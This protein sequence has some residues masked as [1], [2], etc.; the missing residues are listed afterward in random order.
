M[1]PMSKK[2][3]QDTKNQENE[4]RLLLYKYMPYEA[5]EKT[6]ENWSL[7]L[8]IPYET[9]DPFEFMARCQHSKESTD[10][11]I[12]TAIKNTPGMLCF[13]TSMTVASMW[14][15]YADKH[16]GVCLIFDFPCISKK[17]LVMDPNDTIDSYLIGNNENFEKEKSLLLLIF[18]VIYSSQRP[19]IVQE[20]LYN[21]RGDH[22]FGQLAKLLS[23]KDQ[24]WEIEKEHRIFIPI[25]NINNSIKN[26]MVLSSFHMKYLKGVILGPRCPYSKDYTSL[27][28]T[29]QP[30]KLNIYK[31]EYHSTDYKIISTEWLEVLQEMK[32]NLIIP[33]QSNG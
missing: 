17:F 21:D 33:S 9:N 30:K 27:W 20:N 14:G 10:K 2:I 19:P 6:I 28:V 3:S 18:P 29:Q 25:K 13:S 16:K 1:S 31:G 4:K 32:P 24:S 26:R 11:Y 22:K 8:T 12:I 23:T 7:K 15:H 5:F